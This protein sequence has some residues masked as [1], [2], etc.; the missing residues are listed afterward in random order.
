MLDEVPAAEPL[1]EARRLSALAET[2][3][4]TARLLGGAAVALSASAPLPPALQRAYK[5]LDYVVT[6]G[7]ASR[8]ASLIESAGYE[9]DVQFNKLHG[10]GRLLHYDTINV[11]HLDTFV[12]EFAMCHQLNLE[13]RLPRSGATLAPEDILLTKLQIFEVNDKDLIDTIALLLTHAVVSDSDSGINRERF[14]KVVGC[15]WG[16]YTTI[17]DNIE[18]VSQRLE[19]VGLDADEVA[20]VYTRIHQIKAALEAAPKNLKWRARAALGRRLPW[21]DLPEEI[22]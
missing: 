14:M 21:Y 9:P 4:I 13:K 8:W 20:T 2:S 5:D 3:G 12:G 7:H 17:S 11:R 18:K 19:S 1:V 6:R 15:D 22:E 10:A 16:W